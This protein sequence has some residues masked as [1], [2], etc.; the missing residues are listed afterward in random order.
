MD[1]LSVKYFKNEN[2][3]NIIIIILCCL[4]GFFAFKGHYG[5]ILTDFGREMLFPKAIL[6][7]KVLYKDILGIYFPL[8]YQINALGYKFFGINLSV[9]EFLGLI[10][11]FIFSISLYLLSKEF[12]KSSFSLLFSITITVC[13]AFNGSLFNLLLPYSSSMSY[14][15]TAYVISVLFLIKY[16]KQ[17]KIIYINTA[18]LAAGFALACKSEF[19][20]LFIILL[21]SSVIIKPV[22]FKINILNFLLY[23]LF[24]AISLV[25]LFI[26]G[27]SIQNLLSAV[28][29]M[30]KFFTTDSMLYHISRTGGIFGI[31]DI[32]LYFKC[33]VC[34]LIFFGISFLLFKFIAKKNTVLYIISALLSAILA[35][36][37]NVSIHTVLLPLLIFGILIFNYKRLYQNKSLFVL[38]ISAL[39][40]NIRTFWSL[41]LTLYGMF[42]APVLVLSFIVLLFEYLPEFK[43]FKKDDLKKFTVFIL[44]SYLIF[45]TWFAI[46][47]KNK[48]NTP[49]IT[50]K[51][52]IYLVKNQT[53]TLSA[54]LKYIEMY[55]C[56]KDKI[57]VLPEGM[58]INFFA[59][60]PVDYL[61]PMADRL[62]FDAIGE[63]NVLENLKSADYEIVFVIKGYGLTNFGKPYLYNDENKIIKYLN[64]TYKL[65]WEMKYSEKSH[66][67]IIKCYVKPY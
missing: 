46:Y 29:F 25:A 20:I 38:I 27:L 64:E 65:D 28:T 23:F 34:N 10:N 19:G 3:F 41:I 17:N 55:T 66:E 4:F 50:N 30:K 33:L 45:F 40:L 22:S 56:K 8:A 61:M 58:A 21:L 43:D 44:F 31:Q 7:G 18:F 16:I 54:A 62:Y 9:L 12:L 32:F 1:K 11:T 52:K 53:E 14:G 48:N 6:D 5:N 37:T 60:R 13:A 59:D 57:L 47:Q 26:Q 15:A 42:T 63:N 51:G 67:N 36:K 2:T 49:L 35:N 24:P 39:A